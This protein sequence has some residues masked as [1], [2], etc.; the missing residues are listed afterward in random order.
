M[1]PR[2]G[3]LILV[4]ISLALLAAAQVTTKNTT[5]QFQVTSTTFVNN[6]TLPL[7]TIHNIEMNGVNICSL[8]GSM[9]GNQSPELSWTNA[10]AGTKSFAV[11]LFD[12]T[13]SFTHWGMY[14]VSAH[15][16]QLPLNAGAANSSFGAQV[17][18]DFGDPGYDGPCPPPGVEPTVHHYVFTV[19]A[20]DSVLKLS[21][22]ANFP[23]NA[24]TLY[25][26]LIQAGRDGHIL[27]SASIT[28]LFSSTPAD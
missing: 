23:A 14:N 25:H 10:P 5:S 2:L 16:R 15:T 17:N 19:Y 11:V 4:A 9:G 27:D 7:S 22:S 12:I 8:D 21:S 20:L 3:I 13:A 26:A 18:N 1:K 24:E 6:Q 28:G